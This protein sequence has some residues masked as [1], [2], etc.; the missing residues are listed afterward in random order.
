MALDVETA[1]RNQYREISMKNLEMK[2]IRA[3]YR[4]IYVYRYGNAM[5]IHM[6]EMKYVHTYKICM[7]HT[8]RRQKKPCKLP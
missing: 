8:N 3:T 6:Y 2:C 5:P 4:C 7:I 1:R